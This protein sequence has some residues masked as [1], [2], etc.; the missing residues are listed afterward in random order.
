[1]LADHR[2]GGKCYLGDPSGLLAVY[3]RLS[4]VIQLLDNHSLEG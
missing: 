2:F 4:E 3:K 1:M